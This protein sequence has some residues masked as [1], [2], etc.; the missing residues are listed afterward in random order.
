MST[1]ESTEIVVQNFQ[2]EIPEGANMFSEQLLIGEIAETKIEHIALKGPTLQTLPISKEKVTIL[3]F[4]RGKG[5]LL[6]D[7]NYELVPESIAVPMY[8]TTSVRIEVPTGEQLHYLKFTKKLSAQDLED[9]AG[10]SAKNKLDLFV[11]RFEDCEPYV[12]KIKSPNTTSRT[13]L[14]AGIVPR[15]SLGTVEALGPDKVGAHK[16][17]ML[18][19]LFLGLT[20]N[21]IH[22]YADDEKAEMGEYSL[23][24][25][26]LGSNHWVS[27]GENKKMYYLWMDFFLTKDGEEWLKTHKPVSTK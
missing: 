6:A 4:I 14:P 13:V 22:V 12:E 18:D 3:I 15:V 24:H 9:L 26:P 23:L 8:N 25:I 27:V 11:T 7:S 2:M 10:F 1:K 19:Q 17:P 21:D 16:H 20:K 5:T